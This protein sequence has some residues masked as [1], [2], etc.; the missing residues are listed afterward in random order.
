MLTFSL[1]GNIR[2]INKKWNMLQN[3]LLMYEPVS[4]YIDKQKCRLFSLNLVSP[5]A[6]KKSLVKRQF[7]NSSF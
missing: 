5:L 2:K 3:V 4:F 6:M 1:P 7:A